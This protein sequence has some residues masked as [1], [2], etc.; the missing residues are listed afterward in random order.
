M[1]LAGLLVGHDALRS[2]NDG[3]T[4]ALQ[5]MGQLVSAGINAQ[6]GLRDAAQAGNDL[7]LAG[8]SVLQGNADDTLSAVR[9]RS[10]GSS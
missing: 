6:A 2:G 3:N 1:S 10:A 5:D 9:H 4:Q 8:L 7:F